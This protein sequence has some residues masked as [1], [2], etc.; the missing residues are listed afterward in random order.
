MKIQQLPMIILIMIV[1]GLALLQT[2]CD[3]GVHDIS[4][5]DGIVLEL[6]ANRSQA[7]V[8]VPVQIQFTIRNT[9]KKT[10][11]FESQNSPVMDI[12]VKESGGGL[13]LSWSDQNPDKVTHHIEWK[14]GESKTIELT[15]LPKPGDIYVGY[16]RDIDL[17]GHLSSN[18]KSIRSASVRICAS[19]ICR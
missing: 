7:Q 15:W 14:S 6:R 11:V 12:V 18:S 17:E 10:I 16:R 4:T 2:A 19:D 8:D 3:S 5:I 1:A 9:S 13:L